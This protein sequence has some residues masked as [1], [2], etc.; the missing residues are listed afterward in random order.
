MLAAEALLQV[1]PD[2]GQ[3]T[4]SRPVELRL[5]RDL[6]VRADAEPGAEVSCSVSIDVEGDQAMEPL[7]GLDPQVPER[8][9]ATE[10]DTPPSSRGVPAVP[11]V[12]D[13]PPLEGPP[14]L[15]DDDIARLEAQYEA[16]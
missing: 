11:S 13:Y 1:H 5:E 7:P 12:P 9:P 15:T 6:A 2:V 14:P 3:A 16:S 4:A 10:P 8:N